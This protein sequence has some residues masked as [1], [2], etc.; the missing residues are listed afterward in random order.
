MNVRRTLMGIG[1]IVA[2]AFAAP[3]AAS[4]DTRVADAAMRRDV[5]AVRALI[6]QS[7]DVN[8][9]QG[10]GMTALHWAAEHGNEELAALLLQ[11]GASPSAVTRIG[12]HTPLH[13]AAT[14]GHAAV[15]RR[16]LDAKADANAVTTTGATPLHFAAASGNAEAIV[17]LLDRGADVNARE[18]EWGQTPLMFAAGNGRTDAVKVLLKHGA[19]V[20][21][22]GKVINIS[23]R[24]REDGA[25]SRARNARIAEIQKQRAAA[26]AAA[27]RA[28][29]AAARPPA[30]RG[31]RGDDGG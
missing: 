12:R 1:L 21:T 26:A 4:V 25:D 7:A 20:E 31:G 30:A 22:T 19:T 27:A 14:G 15:V 24:N 16:L 2:L 11:A 3:R 29:G 13:V 5:A 8:G 6:R 23:A 17:L 28:S 10:D 9:P 18:P